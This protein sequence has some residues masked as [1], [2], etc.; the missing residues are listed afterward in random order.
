MASWLDSSLLVGAQAGFG[1]AA[2]GHVAL[3]CEKPKWTPSN[4]VQDFDLLTGQIGA[5]PEKLVGRRSATLNFK[6][7]LEGLLATYTG[8]EAI[9]DVSPM[10]FNMIQ[11]AMGCSG[12]PVVAAPN[13]VVSATSTAIT[14]ESGSGADYQAGQLF[15]S[16]LSASSIVPQVGWLKSRSSDVMTLFEASVNTVNDTLGDVFPSNVAWQ[17]NGSITPSF[18]GFKLQGATDGNKVVFNDCI[19]ESFKITWEAGA[20]PTIEFTYK[21]YDF[22]ADNTTAGL[23]VPTEYFRIPQIVG[24]NNGRATL[25]G[26]AQCSLEACELTWSA[27]IIDNKCHGG[28]QGMTAPLASKP[29]ISLT[30]SIPHDSA[31]TIYDSVGAS[32]TVG[33]SK[34][35]SAFELGT[36]KSVGI[37]VGS[38]VGR[39]FSM[40]VPSGLLQATPSPEDRNGLLAYKLELRAATYSGDTAMNG[41]TDANSAVNSV[42]RIGIA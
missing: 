12:S 33:Q 13:D 9:A 1:S 15:V 31:D 2:T 26:T 20:V 38:K 18:V 37:Y 17:T 10:W 30:F 7:P 32:T 34:W 5:A 23:S 19:C 21:C 36:R 11:S 35:Q 25:G 40:L 4:E 8:A 29:R 24:A 16:A 14:M 28:T 42:F 3:L 22:K 41:E 6:M 27:T 39:I